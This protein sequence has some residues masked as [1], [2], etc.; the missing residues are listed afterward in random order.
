[1]LGEWFDGLFGLGLEV[2]FGF[3]G[4]GVALVRVGFDWRGHGGLREGH[5]SSFFMFIV[6]VAVVEWHIA[7][8]LVLY[9]LV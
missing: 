5:A 3:R 6:V 9:R 8:G 1:M 7:D 2:K 4:V